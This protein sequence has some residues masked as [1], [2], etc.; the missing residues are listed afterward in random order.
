VEAGAS[1]VKLNPELEEKGDLK[2]HQA[3]ALLGPRFNPLQGVIIEGTI[4]TAQMESWRPQYAGFY[5]EE[6]TGRGVAVLLQIGDPMWRRSLIGNL[7]L[8]PEWRFEC[9]DE[10]GPGCA[11]VTGIDSDRKHTFRLWIKSK[12]FELYID[13]VLMQTFVTT[14]MT[15]RVGIAAQNVPVTFGELKMW[16]MNL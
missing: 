4:E 10:T 12:S 13:D 2:D 15:G 5:I 11:T 16:H 1:A 6:A 3:V 9:L 7:S 14:G 8:T